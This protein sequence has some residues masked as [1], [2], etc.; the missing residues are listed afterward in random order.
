[1]DDSTLEEKRAGNE[2]VFINNE[3]LSSLLPAS[4]KSTSTT[5]SNLTA[6]EFLRAT[7]IDAGGSEAI[8]GG[9]YTVYVL[10][11]M[12]LDDTFQWEALRGDLKMIIFDGIQESP[13]LRLGLS[14]DD[15]VSEFRRPF[16]W[17]LNANYWR[18]STACSSFHTAY[19][20]HRSL[21]RAEYDRQQ[22]QPSNSGGDEQEHAAAPSSNWIL[23]IMDF[24]DH[25]DLIQCDGDDEV[26]VDAFHTKHVPY[27]KRSVAHH[28]WY[29]ETDRTV[30]KGTLL[31]HLITPEQRRVYS[32]KTP[33]TKKTTSTADIAKPG[34]KHSRKKKEKK[35]KIKTVTVQEDDYNSQ[36]RR[37]NRMEGPLPERNR[38]PFPPV[39]DELTTT[40]STFQPIQHSP[41]PVRTDTV[42]VLH[43]LLAQRGL[44]L[45]SE[46]EKSTVLRRDVSVSHFWPP[47][48]FEKDEQKDYGKYRYHVSQAII[49]FQRE[50]Q[51]QQHQD[52]EGF[53]ALSDIAIVADILGKNAEKGRNRAQEEYVDAMLNSQIIVVTQRDGWEDHYRLMEA[54]ISGAL[55]MT[56][57]MLL[58][59]NGLEHQSSIIVYHNLTELKH[60]LRYYL[61]HE[62]E[63]EDIARVGRYIAMDRHRTWHRMEE[64][65]FGRILSTCAELQRYYATRNMSFSTLAGSSQ[66]ALLVDCPYMVHANGSPN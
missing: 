44:T 33:E 43:E 39:P 59:P 16:V 50:Q 64:I 27:Y 20:R 38:D 49:E 42:Q 52:G 3:G 37:R 45:R 24:Y 11:N 23:R 15:T 6:G 1:M 30:H 17:L 41:F 21:R 63:R 34:K 18:R 31:P 10:P 26:M 46:I 19:A 14:L 56:D 47:T 35:K 61:I 58:L 57:A 9:P 8:V 28:R 22:L 4:P 13:Y 66:P 7:T 40:V 48:V 12:Y 54:L 55:V 65:V 29:N 62:T 51:E 32:E 53:K 5:Y 25:E 36:R 2:L 60:Y